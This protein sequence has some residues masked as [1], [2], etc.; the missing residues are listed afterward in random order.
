MNNR[1]K[2]CKMVSL[3]GTYVARAKCSRF[4]SPAQR[5]VVIT[6]TVLLASVN[7]SLTRRFWR[8]TF[9]RL[10]AQLGFSW[11]CCCIGLPSG[12]NSRKIW[13]STK[14]V[15]LKFNILPTTVTHF[16]QTLRLVIPTQDQVSWILL[17]SALRPIAALT[18]WLQ[19]LDSVQ[20]LQI[21]LDP[22]VSHLHSLGHS[23]FP[24]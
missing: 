5:Y 21:E 3:F 18:H 24:T 22:N 8:P 9:K 14:A 15:F 1:I 6:E 4:T 12:V 23:L 10:W 17:S 13:H 11:L 7:R 19:N 16:F 20:G 2:P